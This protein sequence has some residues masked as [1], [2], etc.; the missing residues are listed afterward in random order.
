MSNNVEIS[1]G[2]PFLKCSSNPSQTMYK[3]TNKKSKTGSTKLI[4]KENI[5]RIG[6]DPDIDS[7]KSYLNVF[8]EDITHT[9]DYLEEIELTKHKINKELENKNLKKLRKDTVDNVSLVVKPSFAAMAE[10]NYDNQLKFLKDS[11]KSIEKIFKQINKNFKFSVAIAHFDEVSPHLHLNFMPLLYDEEKGIETFNAKKFLSLKNITLLNKNY[12]KQM[13]QLGWNVRDF[14]IYEEMTKEEKEEYKK[15]KK[16]HGRTSLEFK[17]D[18]LAELEEELQQKTK[19]KEE[20]KE[21]LS[22]DVKEELEPIIAKELRANSE[23]QEKAKK[24]VLDTLINNMSEEE[25]NNR[26]IAEQNRR[27]DELYDENEVLHDSLKKEKKK[28]NVFKT[29]IAKIIKIIPN[30]IR[31]T[32]ENIIIKDLEEEDL[33]EIGE[34]IRNISEDEEEASH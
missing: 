22:T 20:L 2:L 9:D 15:Q 1:V 17:A 5:E 28:N 34:K 4:L 29:I 16:L 3:K 27:I 13:Q 19:L 12:S 33:K 10:L 30:F 18:K 8:L 6:K 25:K 31:E 7:S 23:I 32:I 11:K 26:I 24:E 14:N 21:K